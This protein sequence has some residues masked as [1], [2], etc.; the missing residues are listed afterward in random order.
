MK[1]RNGVSNNFKFIIDDSIHLTFS[2]KH[3]ALEEWT[4][5]EQWIYH[6]F[7]DGSI[8]QQ[9]KYLHY[10]FRID[11]SEAIEGPDADKIAI[12][13]NKEKT[14]SKLLLVP[15]IDLGSRYFDVISLKSEGGEGEKKTF[16]QIMDDSSSPGNKG[17]VITYRTRLPRY[18]WDIVDPSTQQGISA[19]PFEEYIN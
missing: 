13:R 12:V 9:F 15:H 18:G 10:F 3:Q 17:L 7:D 11:W 8:E 4:D 19:I 16:S 6:K 14:G 1:S 5:E 2:F